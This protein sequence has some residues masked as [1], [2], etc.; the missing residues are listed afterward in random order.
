MMKTKVYLKRLSEDTA[1][2]AG[3]GVVFDGLD[4]DGESFHADTDYMLD[5]VPEKPILYDH[6]ANLTN[7]IGS[8]KNANIRQDDVGL[9]IEAELD[10]HA[11]Y[12]DAVLELAEKG[13]LGW[14]SGTIGQ[15]ARRDGKA[16]KTWPIVEWSLTPTPAEPRTLG[17]ERI[18]AL[19]DSHPQL[20]AL[21]AEVAGTATDEEAAQDV[22]H[23]LKKLKLEVD[24]LEI[25]HGHQQN[26]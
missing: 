23:I 5:L 11:A 16:I 6:G 25:T 12:V 18:K 13:V 24:V 3:Y 14:S 19:W 8:V 2:V 22:D 17:V 20:K 10:R 26:A 4:L 15:L 9:W 7:I 1:T 21:F